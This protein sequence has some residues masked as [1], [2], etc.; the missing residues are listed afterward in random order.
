MYTYLLPWYDEHQ[1]TLPWRAPAGQK[2]NPYYVLLSEIMLQQTTVPTVIS[3]FNRF[4]EKWPTLADFATASLDEIYH[5]WQG[6][7]YYSRAKNLHRCIQEICEKHQGEIPRQEDILRTLPGIGPYTAAAVAAIAYDAPTVPVDGNIVRVFTRFHAILT[8]LPALKT[9]VFQKIHTITPPH[10]SGDFAQSLMDLGSRICQPRKAQCPICPL[11]S[12][13]KGYATGLADELPKR[14]IKTKVPTRYGLIFWEETPE[15]YVRINRRPDKGLLA[16]LIE[17]PG[18]DWRDTPWSADDLTQALSTHRNIDTI[19]WHWI[20]GEVKHTFTHFHLHLKM[21]KIINPHA[22]ITQGLW[23]K[24]DEFA[25]Y[26]LP[27]VM[28]KV[29][30]HIQKN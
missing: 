1:R 13:C 22:D 11:Q 27:T 6:L 26:P 17:I 7:G 2:P 21:I 28:K 16:N 29:I 18:T 14:G 23:A 25:T 15:G 10:R 30:T 12:Q 3:Y 24:K 20:D 8:P 19:T 5:A 4:I 9:E